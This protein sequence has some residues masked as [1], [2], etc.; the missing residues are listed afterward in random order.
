MSESPEINPATGRLRVVDV[1]CLHRVLEGDPV[2]EELILRF[3]GDRWGAPNLF[4]LPV[5][6]AGEI[7]RR[8]GDFIRAAKRYYEPELPF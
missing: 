6:V 7:L 5:K 4:Y 1:Q 2:T 3:I 8:P